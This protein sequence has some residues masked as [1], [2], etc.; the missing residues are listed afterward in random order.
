[1]GNNLENGE[2]SDIG[3]QLPNGE[4]NHITRVGAAGAHGGWAVCP[5]ISD[6]TSRER[7]SSLMESV[8]RLWRARTGDDNLP[9]DQREKRHQRVDALHDALVP[10]LDARMTAA[11]W[12]ADP[13]AVLG[14]ADGVVGR[15]RHPLNED[16]AATARF[17]WLGDTPP[18]QV[19][20]AVGV[21]YRRSYRVWPYLLRG[22]P[23]SELRVGVEDLG[24][25]SGFVELWELDEVDRA[26]DQLIAPVLDRALG[27]AGPFASFDSLLS[28]LRTSDNAEAHLMDIPVL[29]AAGG[30]LDEARQALTDA[31]ASHREEAE[32]LLMNDFALRFEVWLAGGTPPTPPGEPPHPNDMWAR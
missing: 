3:T 5:P 11:G 17:A 14:T 23:H 30:R 28:T 1:L 13:T 12:H 25:A 21:S 16:F 22:Y 10:R 26:V 8:C 24:Q 31:L 18:L 4:E 15:F 29:L 9:D 20:T 7:L 32:D 19:D 2:F 27:W 6:T